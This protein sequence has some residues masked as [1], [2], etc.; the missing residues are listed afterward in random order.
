M[1]HNGMVETVSKGFILVETC[2]KGSLQSIRMHDLF[3][4]P[5]LHLNLL[6]VSKLISK[7]LKVHFNLLECMVDQTTVSCWPLH[8]CSINCI[9][10]IQTL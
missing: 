6:S 8:L 7:G 10:W 3:Y 4:M 1:G 9:N 5:N 2:V